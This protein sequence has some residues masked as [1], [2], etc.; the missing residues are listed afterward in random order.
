[1]I[2]TLA[3]IS[4]GFVLGMRHAMDPDH[5]IAVTTIVSRQKSVAKAGF[6]GVLWGLGHTITIFLLGA[7]IILFNVTIPPRLGL[8][9]ELSVGA[10]LVLL[11]GL[12]LSGLT[13]RLTERLTPASEAPL[14]K[15]KLQSETSA[16]LQ[17]EQADF[18]RSEGCIDRTIRG[19]G[20]FQTLRPLC[21][22]IV[23]GMAG[24]A[25]IALLLMSTIRNPWW[26]VSYLLVFGL[27]T[28]A[29]MMTITAIIAL[30]FAYSTKKFAWLNRGLMIASGVISVCFGFFLA[31]QIAFVDG[32]FT[33]HPQWTPR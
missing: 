24:S 25:A 32:L 21:V 23:H 19:M 26:A 17:A 3:I 5:V 10:M 9:M 30:P 16:G 12:N 8:A 29:G 18:N 7:A 1:M 14:Q 20:A 27:G 2:S 15:G 31:Y 33:N 13:R 11:G 6:I 22:G 4:I 28:I